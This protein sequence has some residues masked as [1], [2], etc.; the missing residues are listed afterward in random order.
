MIEKNRHYI[1]CMENNAYT[2]SQVCKRIFKLLECG[3]QHITSV[4]FAQIP[5]TVQIYENLFPRGY[6]CQSHKL[7]QI[8][9]HRQRKYC[10]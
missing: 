9:K 7:N 4:G 1:E 6:F 10:I 3:N 8:T 5:P 2:S